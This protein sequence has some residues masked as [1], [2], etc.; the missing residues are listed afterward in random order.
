M[1]VSDCE[2][3]KK[4]IAAG[5]TGGIAANGNVTAV[6]LITASYRPKLCNSFPIEYWYVKVTGAANSVM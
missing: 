5:F 3:R 6:T 4:K 2:W 1:W